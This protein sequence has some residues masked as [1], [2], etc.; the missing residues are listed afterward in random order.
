MCAK[1]SGVS[2]NHFHLK[3]AQVIRVWV[4]KK[5]KFCLGA[6]YCSLVY[7]CLDLFIGIHYTSTFHLPFFTT[8]LLSLLHM[9]PRRILVKTLPISPSQTQCLCW[10]ERLVCIALALRAV[11]LRPSRDHQW[12]WLIKWVWHAQIHY[13]YM[14]EVCIV[15]ISE[16]MENYLTTLSV[17]NRGE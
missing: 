2:A 17:H 7:T 15:H 13:L 1:W 16:W 11:S 8:I 12:V 5:T 10:R 9:K 3:S 4:W 6:L 14:H